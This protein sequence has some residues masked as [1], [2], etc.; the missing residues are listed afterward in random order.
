MG[1]PFTVDDFYL[2]SPVPT[3]PFRVWHHRPQLGPI[4]LPPFR[5]GSWPNPVSAPRSVAL[6]LV[7]AN[8]LLSPVIVAGTPFNQD[9]WAAPASVPKKPQ[10][11]LFYYI[12]D[13][14]KPGF[15]NYDWPLA[16]K[17]PSLVADPITNRLVLPVVITT[18]PFH[19]HDWPLAATVRVAKVWDPYN[20]NV[21]LP[22]PVGVPTHQLDW[23]L[24]QRARLVPGTHTLND[25]GVLSL[26]VGVP[27]R[28]V[29]WPT[30][31]AILLTVRWELEGRSAIYMPRFEAEWAVNSNQ[32]V[33]PRQVQP[34]T[35]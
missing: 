2:P 7:R 27:R 26:P 29:E 30:P 35:H 3:Q 19:Q 13:Q 11:F 1:V 23:P 25:L 6:E 9:D 28:P 14:T 32:V 16:P 34:V 33:G 20:R 4:I 5:E 18:T 17:R 15:I 24:P 22:V 12:Q 8:A 10:E 31:Q 21:F